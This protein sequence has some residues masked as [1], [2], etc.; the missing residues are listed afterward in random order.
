MTENL[1][2]KVSYHESLIY[3]IAKTLK[4]KG[5][6]IADCGGMEV[7]EPQHDVLGI[8]KP[9]DSVEKS[10][11][12]FK[13]YRKQ[14]ALYLGNLWIDNQARGASPQNWVLEVYGRDNIPKLTELARELSEPTEASVQVILDSEQERLERYLFD[15]RK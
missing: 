15:L 9:R 11:L 6:Q 1:T 3:A 5:Y 10:F 8:L 7:S 13:W 12:G 2:Q 14:R 4:D